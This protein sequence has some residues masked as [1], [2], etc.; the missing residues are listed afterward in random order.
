MEIIKD[1]GIRNKYHQGFTRLCKPTEITIHGTGGGPGV[2]K[3]MYGGERSKYYKKG[4]GLF[5]YLI[6]RNGKTTE[7]IDP[8]NWVWHSSSGEHDE[9]TIGIELVNLSPG[10]LLGYTE[11]Q[12]L[13]LFQLIDFLYEKYPIKIIRSHNITKKI[14]SKSKRG[15][16]CPGPRF[17]W[18]KLARYLSGMVEVEK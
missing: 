6:K 4:I 18:E 1:T 9:Y 2:L 11:A 10:N 14:W 16:V 3:W 17:D 12:Y 15:K 13:S 8:K 5:H 7:V